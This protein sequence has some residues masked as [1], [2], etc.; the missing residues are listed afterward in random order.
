MREDPA[1]TGWVAIVAIVAAM[2]MT[3]GIQL[4][5]LY[6]DHVD[7]RSQLFYRTV[8]EGANGFFNVG[9]VVMDR[10]DFVR[11][12]AERAIDW[13]PTHALGPVAQWMGVGPGGEDDFESATAVTSGSFS[14]S[15]YAAERLGADDPAAEPDDCGCRTGAPRPAAWCLAP[16]PLALLVLR[17]RRRS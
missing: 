10:Y 15:V 6:M 4:A 3:P 17:R 2:L 14:R 11:Y 8:S 7:V 9:V 1:P 12:F 5:L 13:Y 16:V